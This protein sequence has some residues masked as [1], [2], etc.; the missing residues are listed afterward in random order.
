M[1]RFLIKKRKLSEELPDPNNAH[2]VDVEELPG[3][4]FNPPNDEVSASKNANVRSKNIIRQYHESYLSFGFTSSGG[5]MPIPQCLMCSEK[6]SNES[7]VPSKLK[8]HLLT[9]HGFASE[10]PLDFFKRLASDQNRQASKF[11]KHSTV[12]DK[13]QEARYA[14]AELI[15]KKMKSHTTAESTILPACCEIVK[16][17]FG[18]DFEKEVRKIP[19]SNNTVQRRIEDMSNDVEFH[20]N[21][22]LKAAELFALQLDE[23]T[24][25]TGKP[26]VMTFVRFICDNELIEQFL[27]CKDLPET[28]RGQDIFNLVNNY[29][30][31]ANISWKFCL[32]VCTDGCPSMIGHLTGFLALVKKENPDI[33]FTH[34]F[35]HREAL[36]AKSLMP[37]LNEVLQTVVKMVNFIKSKPLKSRLFNQLCSAMDSE[38]TQLLFHTEVRWLSRGR[39]LQRFYELREELLLFFTCEESKYADF[40][41]D[42]SWCAK[43]AFLADIFEKLN[44]LN[45]SMQGKQ[46]NILTSTDKI[47]SFQQKLLLWISKIE[48]QTNWDMFDLVKNCHVNSDLTNL[49]LKSLH[50]LY[51]NIKKY[52]PSLDVS[53]MDWVRNP[54]IDSAYESA[55]FTTDEE[56]EL[57]DI[58]NDRGLKLQYSK[59]V[60]DIARES[61]LK[62][63]KINVDVSSFWINLLHEYPKISR[64]A[65]NA[66]LPFSTSYICEAAFSSMNAIKNKN[67]SQLKNLEDDMRVCLSTIRPR[68][69][70]IMKRKQSQISH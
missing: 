66:I 12:S 67:R 9:K 21:E 50:L 59:L 58:K 23:S 22:K 20:V 63:I 53:S 69:N 47:S 24:D 8:R 30:T 52:F 15:A 1:D 38:H 51:E 65:M 18:E 70:L 4:S 13:A 56:S 6:L 29:F 34:C 61:K 39:V 49:I 16:I 37:E 46:E 41:S 64:K 14:V 44:Y 7:M 35:I 25:V 48:K 26:Q 17:L 42:D 57:I 40:L 10:K 28:T 36:V 62:K 19:L 2:R 3:P 5:E 68:R 33:I 27:F 45:K 32:S 54:F 60:E 11:I 31:T 55:L 43:V